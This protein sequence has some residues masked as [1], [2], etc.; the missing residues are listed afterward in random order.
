MDY[1]TLNSAI[2]D[3]V[4]IVNDYNKKDSY[5]VSVCEDLVVAL[6][7]YYLA[8]GP[9]VFSKVD[10]IL[11][12]LKIHQTTTGKESSEIK[13]QIRPN[14]FNY[15]DEDPE[16]IWEMKF[17]PKTNKFL[18]AIPHIVYDKDSPE[19]AVLT[20]THELSHTLEGC[21]A[22]VIK[23][24]KNTVTIR[25]GFSE[26]TYDKETGFA[27]SGY[28]HGMTELITVTIENK[29]LKEY[30]N[31]NP[32]NIENP[33]IKGFVKKAN[34]AKNGQTLAKSYL[35]MSGIFKDLIDNEK[36]FDIVKEHYY[37]TNQEEFIENFNSLDSRLNF[38]RLINYAEQICREEG[39]AT[40]ILRVVPQVQSQL[41]VLN[42]VTATKPSKSLVLFF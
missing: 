41:D 34:K 10:Q 20:L 35:T 36:F 27:I 7:G 4:D 24:D 13:K 31:L 32:D 18:G 1:D 19:D 28:G 39:N 14:K 22:Q 3:I 26:L 38:K 11:S 40:Q 33:L 42:E 30:S 29:V 25:I 23:E 12:A 16:T 6:T 21:T 37:E 15:T 2:S 8:F 9:K 17:D 5:T